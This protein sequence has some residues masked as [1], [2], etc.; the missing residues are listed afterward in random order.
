MAAT[1]PD[2]AREAQ[3]RALGD[4]LAARAGDVLELVVRRC[5]QDG[6]EPPAQIP[7]GFARI[8]LAATETVARAIAAESTERDMR[9]GREA[10]DVFGRMPQHG[11]AP[12]HEVT[13]RCLW[14]RDAV[15]AVLD[16]CATRLGTSPEV[17]AG[18][19]ALAQMTLDVTLIRIG[20]AYEHEREATLRE[21]DQR[22]EDVA[23]R[24]THDPLTGLPNRRL[25]I[26]RCEHMLARSRRTGAG[27]AAVAI[28]LDDIAALID[29]L[30][31]A[32]GEDLLRAVAERLDGLVRDVDALARLGADEFGVLAEDLTD[33]DE[34]EV[35][36]GRLAAG[37]AEPFFLAGP[38]E[39]AVL[40]RVSVGVATGRRTGAGELLR[41]AEIAMRRARSDGV[42]SPLLYRP[43]MHDPVPARSEVEAELRG[44]LEHGELFLL[45]QPTFEL[46]E[47]VPT[48]VEALLRWRRRGRGIVP[49]ADFL[50]LLEESGLIV[51]VGAW[52]LREACERCATLRREGHG[53]G[54]SVNISERQLENEQFVQHVRDAL[55]TS[56]L[57]PDGL[58]LEIAETVVM[59]DAVETAARLFELR[60]LG[61]R[62]AIDD[63]GTG[64]SSLAHLE[65]FPVDAL[66]IDRSFVSQLDAS[67]EARTLIRTLIQLGRALA[68]DTLAKGIEKETELAILRAES[69][70][71]GQGFLFARPLEARAASE[72]LARWRQAPRPTQAPRAA[73]G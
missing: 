11:A 36:A 69:C 52:V 44:A 17:L 39:P 13:R 28:G 16:S 6:Q 23:Y 50:P 20:E 54:V 25:L 56:G 46:R 9:A 42:A 64:T 57:E 67:P 53:V 61:V 65:R 68:F 24:A 48:G 49:P 45:Y 14:W 73:T 34:A 5:G 62:V 30:G 41:D 29:T 37:L 27:V 3:R 40:L 38:K 26:D 33:P 4:A 22:Q 72:F 70:G 35:I 32:P 2:A 21:L 55:G 60:D 71:A 47:L 8:C 12:L 10:W 59:A 7:S 31:E 58:T 15:V 51:D 1:E 43:G 19:R 63:F 18:A 66:K